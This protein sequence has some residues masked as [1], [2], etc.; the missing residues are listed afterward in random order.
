MYFL[1]RSLLS[2]DEL[3]FAKKD[4]GSI[5][6]EKFIC[7]LLLRHLI[8][9]APLSLDYLASPIIIPSRNS[10]LLIQV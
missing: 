2:I 5:V 10:V 1:E 6:V 4:A 7:S 9:I 8:R 3:F